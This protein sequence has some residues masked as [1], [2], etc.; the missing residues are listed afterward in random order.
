M[1][2]FTYFT[3]EEAR[4]SIIS[5]RV[6]EFLHDLPSEMFALTAMIISP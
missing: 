3:E 2:T 5:F 6:N 1:T 4:A